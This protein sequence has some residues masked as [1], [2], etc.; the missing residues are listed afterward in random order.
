[1]AKERTFSWIRQVF[2]VREV[3]DKT[4]PKAKDGDGKPKP[5]K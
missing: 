4:E 3:P 1:V 5:K 2:E